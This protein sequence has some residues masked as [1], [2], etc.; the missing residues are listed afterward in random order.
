M[1]RE[2]FF[3]LRGFSERFSIFE[4]VEI[5]E[6]ASAMGVVITLPG[7]LMTSS[8]RHD[9]EGLIGRGVLNYF[10]LSIYDS[11]RD[12][13]P[14]LL[15]TDL[16]PLQRDTSRIEFYKYCAIIN[17]VA[18]KGGIGS[19]FRLWRGCG[20]FVA[21]NIWRVFHLVD[22]HIYRRSMQSPGFMLLFHDRILRRFLDLPAF[23]WLFALLLICCF[24]CTW[25]ASSFRSLMGKHIGYADPNNN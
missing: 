18:W 4:D 8:R 22:F 11:N 25:A 19:F 21:K 23:Q 15:G 16:Y 14:E 1:S 9:R 10:L 17:H 2:Y 7:R 13:F 20:S 24:F 6:R 12:E 5:L 3:Y